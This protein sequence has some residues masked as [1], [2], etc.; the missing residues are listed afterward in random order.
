MNVTAK[1]RLAI[2]SYVD[3]EAPPPEDVSTA[4]L[5]FGTNQSTPADLAAELHHQGRAPLIIATGGVN[6]HNGIVEGRMFRQLLLER[7]VPESAIRYEDRSTNTPQN[8]ENALPYINEALAEGL[9]ITG[10]S[11]WFHRR[12]IN[13][14][15]TLVP[16]LGTF[17]ALSWEPVYSG[18]ATTRDN[19]HQIP[20]GERRVLRE[21]NEVRLRIEN[22]S[23]HDTTRVNPGWIR[24]NTP[25]EIRP[26]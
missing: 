5:I 1:T 11:K 6:R 15:A 20:D 18:Q 24:A 14:L 25:C 19:W 26:T 9:P 8:V 17:Y 2:T 3:I 22:G 12:T 7:D 13:L 21:W 10:I 23:L 4:L 16:D